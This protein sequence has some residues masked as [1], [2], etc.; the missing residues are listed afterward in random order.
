MHGI[1][2]RLYDRK[3][4][5]A[6]PVFSGAR[7]VHFVE[8][9]PQMRQTLLG[10]RLAGIKDGHPHRMLLLL[11][12]QDDLSLPAAVVDGVREIVGKNIRSHPPVT[13]D[14]AGL[15]IVHV[16]LDLMLVGEHLRR[17]KE[18]FDVLR[19]VK[20]LHVGHFVAELD[21]VQRQQLLHHAVHLLRLVH[22]H[23]AVKAS[24]LRVIVDRLRQPFRVSLNQGD[25]RLQ[26]MGHIGEK[27]FAH[28]VNLFFF[29]NVL[30]QL[31]VRC[32]QFGDRLLQRL[33]QLVD[34]LSQQP[35]FI[36]LSAR[37]LCLE[38]QLHHLLGN[39]AELLDG[40]ADSAGGKPDDHAAD[41]RADQSGIEEKA[42]CHIDALAD[43]FD[44]GSHNDGDSV[45]ES[46]EH[47]Q[48]IVFTIACLLDHILVRLFDRGIRHPLHVKN[49][50]KQRRLQFAPRI[51]RD[52]FQLRIGVHH[53]HCDIGHTAD[54][55]QFF[56]KSVGL[57]A[58]VV[59]RLSDDLVRPAD[60]LGLAGNI[61]PFQ[62]EIINNQAKENGH[63]HQ[64]RKNQGKLSSDR[65]FHAIASGLS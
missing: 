48:I 30:L 34:I 16:D 52:I 41:E 62:K 57:I 25:R 59:R 1:H 56:H 61:I 40:L 58:A 32:F 23:I 64:A 15:I 21:L 51:R 24:A 47:D 17:R 8:F 53:A 13:P 11:Q 33:G 63:R 22:D 38:L 27:L 49:V 65:L 31:V 60:H 9:L 19:Q 45:A 36:L 20:P 18:G 54:V 7:F 28:L 37:I 50:A 42:V 6:A 12:L 39:I 26:F 43:A 35:D 44:G 46:A 10:N 29:L 3:A 4:D 55:I 14:I 2:Q 5:T